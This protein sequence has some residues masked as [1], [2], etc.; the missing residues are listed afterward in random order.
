MGFKRCL[1]PQRNLKGI[2]SDI[3]NKINIEGIDVVEEAIN[4]L[5]T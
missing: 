5:I 3:F 1:I 2:S 4:A